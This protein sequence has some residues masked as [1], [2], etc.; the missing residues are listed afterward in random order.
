MSNRYVSVEIDRQTTIVSQDGSGL[1]LILSTEKAM[2]YREYQDIDD[3]KTDYTEASETYKLANAIFD[4]EKRPSKVAIYGIL[5][6]VAD[7]VTKLSEALNDLVKTKN[8]FFFVHCTVQEDEDIAELSKWANSQE[9]FYVAST[10]NKTLAKTLN[11]SPNTI[12]MVHPNPE[13]YPA[14]AWVGACTAMNVGSYTWTFKTLKNIPPANYDATTISEIEE[15]N[16]ST[17]ITV[18][19]VNITSKGITTSGEYIDIIQSQY[20]MKSLITRNVF[21]LL[22]RMPKVPF[23]DS[24]IGLVVAEIDKAMKTCAKQG[25]IATDSD[26][27]SLYNISFPSR[28]E[29]SDLDR[30]KRTLPD[31]KWECEIAGAVENVK[32]RGVLKV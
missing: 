2:P 23:D 24:G 11:N 17:Y 18:G 21:G 5:H 29:V 7:P 12:I 1:S 10:T 16:A 32:I 13:F 15:N 20:Y 27:N 3:I 25:I 28:S 14:S 26:G 9:K 22:A 19:G 8:D 30:S 4:Q 6:Q 31:V